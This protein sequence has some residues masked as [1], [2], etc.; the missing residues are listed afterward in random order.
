M[1]SPFTPDPPAAEEHQQQQN[2]VQSIIGNDNK[3]NNEPTSIFSQVKSFIYESARLGM[4]G[5]INLM[6]AIAFYRTELAESFISGGCVALGHFAIR[7][8]VYFYIYKG[9]GFDPR[10]GNSIGSTTAA[11][12]TK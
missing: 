7:K 4:H 12:I 9:K 11:V 10:T 6:S 8:F 2:T 3:G 1:S 5:Y